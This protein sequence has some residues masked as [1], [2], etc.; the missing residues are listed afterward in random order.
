M[1]HACFSP[2]LFPR[3]SFG[4][5]AF[6][7]VCGYWHASLLSVYF[8]NSMMSYSIIML[9]LLLSLLILSSFCLVFYELNIGSFIGSRPQVL[10]WSWSQ[11]VYWSYTCL[12]E[13]IFSHVLF[14]WTCHFQMQHTEASEWKWGLD[15]HSCKWLDQPSHKSGQLFGINEVSP[16]FVF[17]SMHYGRSFFGLLLIV[18]IFHLYRFH[19]QADLLLL[20]WKSRFRKKNLSLYKCLECQ[21]IESLLKYY[22]FLQTRRKITCLFYKECCWNSRLMGSIHY[23]FD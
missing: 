14:Q 1:C 21:M 3:C 15:H 12:C 17:S 7:K 19:R 4:L 8:W 10:F 18:G 2:Y 9:S 22:L 5:S 16:L 23:S 6:V 11:H 13:I 20:V